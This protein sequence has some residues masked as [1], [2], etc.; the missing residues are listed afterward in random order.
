MEVE[1]SSKIKLILL[2]GVI[3]GVLPAFNVGLV[4]G[5]NGDIPEPVFFITILAPSSCPHPNSYAPILAEEL[6]KIGIGIENL[7]M[8]SWPNLFERLWS[9]PGPYPIP[10]Y[11]L[12][13]YD[14]LPL[15]WSSSLDWEPLELFGSSYIVPYGDNLYQYASLEMDWALA[16]YSFSI[17]A[18]KRLFWG[19]KV[20]EILYNDVPACPLTHNYKQVFYDSALT[21]FDFALSFFAYQSIE[22]WSIPKQT[23]FHI[24]VFD[25]FKSFHIFSVYS[26][27]DLFW[28]RQI[29]TSLLK[30][31]PMNH[32]FLSPN[33]ASAINTTDGL[34][35]TIYLNPD[36]VWADGTPLNASDLEYSFQNAQHRTSTDYNDCRRTKCVSSNFTINVLDEYTVEV[37]FEKLTPFPERNLDVSLIP[38]HIWAEIPPENQSQQALDWAL[39]APNKLI[40]AGPYYLYEY[41]ESARVIH[42]KRN[43]Y[44][45]SWSGVLP[46]FEDLFFEYYDTSVSVINAISEGTIDFLYDPFFSLS[47]RDELPE[48]VSYSYLETSVGELVINN[49][50]PIL[51]TGEFCPIA[52][53]QSALYVR[54]AI[55][56]AIDRA[57]HSQSLEEPFGEP[58][59][60]NCPKTA[61]CFNETLEPPALDLQLA[62]EFMR[63]AGYNIPSEEPSVVIGLTFPVFVT[64][65]SLG[66]SSY[67]VLRKR[68]AIKE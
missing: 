28:L 22:N 2:L 35:Y 53:P 56:H 48:G 12:G 27:T 61:S 25:E 66:D 36:V 60:T 11:T 49:K 63:K 43:P 58:A 6:P 33:V 17:D 16:N 34:T 1:L 32:Y 7:V 20:Q 31:D 30:R 4:G 3:T 29:Y 67:L 45:V 68:K 57:L 21:G 38:K 9:Y 39:S 62:K 47:F 44:Y 15:K 19:K 46:K 65:L 52:G 55:N 51:G 40:G 37:T 23:E 10:N 42:L 5:D 14:V 41:N 24:A 8:T 50:H 59:A 54:K 64:I 13:G 26:R 18:Q